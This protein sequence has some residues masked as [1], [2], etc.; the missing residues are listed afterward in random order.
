MKVRAGSVIAI[1]LPLIAAENWSSQFTAW[2]EKH[3][4]RSYYRDLDPRDLFRIWEENRVR[5]EYINSLNLSWSAELGVFGGLTPVEFA[6]TVLLKPSAMADDTHNPVLLR[7]RTL[8]LLPGSFDWS[9][10]GAVT[11][12]KDQGT[13]GS[14]YVCVCVLL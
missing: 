13:V 7:R 8:E 3:G 9:D 5:V 14:W 10:Y 6:T 1:L 11:E 4:K 12:V 2:F